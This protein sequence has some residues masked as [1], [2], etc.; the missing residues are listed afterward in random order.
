MSYYS[1]II[2]VLM[3]KR[4]LPF[5]LI[6][7]LLPIVLAQENSPE[8]PGV[9]PDSFM[10][11]VD[12]AL[13]QIS[14]LLT[15]NPEAK[16]MKGLTIAQERLLEV[17]A[18]AEAKNLPALEKA[19][20]AHEKTLLKVKENIR[21]PDDEDPEDQ[22]EK[23]LE[24]EKG[25]L[26][27]E[28]EIEEIETKLKIKIKIEGQLTAEQ[29]AQLDEFLASLGESAGEVKIEIKNK[30]D[31]TKI[32]VK[33]KGKDGEEVEREIKEKIGLSNF[34]K[35]RAEKM[36]ERAEDKWNDLVEKAQKHAA[37]I[38]DKTEFEALLL[39]GDQALAAGRNEE[40]KDFYEDAKDYTKELKEGIERS[41]ED[42]EEFENELELE[43]E[44]EEGKAKVKIEVGES[45]TEFVLQET[46]REKIVQ[47]IALLLG[48]SEEEVLGLVVF[49][50]EQEE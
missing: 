7:I 35:E 15:T 40:A 39:K 5:L 36:R 27:H 24:L 34:E 11:G 32:K 48:I 19:Q 1:R 33:Q 47:E 22:L 14:L 16:A 41:L 17:R 42:K 9:T 25:L 26:E 28:E 29:Q 12:R 45:E 3:M 21:S 37:E 43:V 13:E 2:E 4:Y 18:M 31:E 30:K 50:E 10:W 38:P 46:D 49:E 23:E 6:L 20:K 8:N 44:I